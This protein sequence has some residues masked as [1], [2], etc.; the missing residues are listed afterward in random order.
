MKFE[1]GYLFGMVLQTVP[2]PRKIAR[3]V[4]NLGAPRAVLWQAL[5]L[6]LVATTFLGVISSILFPVDPDAFG[7]LLSDPI[8]TG[9]AQGSVTVLTVFGIYWIGR[10]LGGTG[11]FDQALLTVIWLQFVLLIV[12]LG[13]LFLGVFAP[14]LAL[15]LWVM[16]M[17]LTFWILSHFIA[18]MHGFR[19]AGAVFAGIFMVMIAL[20]VVM[21]VV[22]ALIGLGVP[23]GAAE[24][25]VS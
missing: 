16:G 11:S 24:M 17:V 12:E 7:A 10:A 14:G 2:E 20:A 19:S 15:L 4:Q 18:E 6:L 13:V 22:F 1:W 3:E 25:G 5:L 8:M 21:S 23:V 9:I